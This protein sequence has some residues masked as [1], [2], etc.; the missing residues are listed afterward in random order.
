MSGRSVESGRIRGCRLYMGAEILEER[1]QRLMT[2]RC[3]PS[4]AH[5]H[6]VVDE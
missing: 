5:E 1:A 6:D 4:R 2:A 3:D